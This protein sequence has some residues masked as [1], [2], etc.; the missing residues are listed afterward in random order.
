MMHQFE[1]STCS[2]SA[3]VDCRKQPSRYEVRYL[4]RLGKLGYTEA[5]DMI[6]RHDGN[7]Y[8]IN[9]ELIARRRT[10]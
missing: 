4:M 3:R 2:K 8:A 1:T 6:S 5:A 7:R 10:A 9:A